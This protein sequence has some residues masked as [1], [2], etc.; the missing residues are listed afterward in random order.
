MKVS[1]DYKSIKDSITSLIVEDEKGRD[2]LIK[3]L[4]EKTAE[5]KRREDEKNQKEVGNATLRVTSPEFLVTTNIP[6]GPK[7]NRME[8]VT[9]PE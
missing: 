7:A 6:T 3:K 8:G 1:T 5:L 9:M 4:K 2:V